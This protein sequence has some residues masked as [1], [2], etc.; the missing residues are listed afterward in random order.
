MGV[1]PISGILVYVFHFKGEGDNT[2]MY[3]YKHLRF[4]SLYCELYA[5]TRREKSFFASR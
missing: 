3:V 1:G 2:C 4:H 5:C